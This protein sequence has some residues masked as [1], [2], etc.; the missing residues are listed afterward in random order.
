[1]HV[2]ACV[3]MLVVR[4]GGVMPLFE[5]GGVK[6]KRAT[7]GGLCTGHVIFFAMDANED[8]SKRSTSPFQHLKLVER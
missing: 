1:M 4:Q 7:R 3:C 5:R 2:R 8:V 6:K